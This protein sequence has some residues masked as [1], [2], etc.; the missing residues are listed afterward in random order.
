MDKRQYREI[1]QR[2]YDKLTKTENGIIVMSEMPIPFRR[3]EVDDWWGDWRLTG[4][5]LELI[6]SYHGNEPSWLYEVDL[7][8]MKSSARV[9][10]YIIQVSKKNWCTVEILANLVLAMDDCLKLQENFCGFGHERKD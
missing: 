8:I 4:E 6:T 7:E 2:Y 9:L 10:D 1:K 5:T 3:P